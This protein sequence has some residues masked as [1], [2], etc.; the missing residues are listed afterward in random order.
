M[1]RF[2]FASLL[3]LCGLGSR[4][5]GVTLEGV[6]LSFAV[7]NVNTDL[8]FSGAELLDVDSMIGYNAGLSLRWRWS[9]RSRFD[10][11]TEAWYQQAGYSFRDENS[12]VT[13][14]QLPLLLR[15]ALG[16][17]DGS[18]YVIFGPSLG[19]RMDDGESP[20]QADYNDFTFAG[21]AGIGYSYAIGRRFGVHGEFRFHGDFSDAYDGDPDGEFGLQSARHRVFQFSAGVEF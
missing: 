4:A 6:G 3:M 20:V 19:F 15:S 11:V 14:L 9:R 16:D 5:E 10:I 7:A 18:V 8:Q 17:Q 1:R 12:V 2:V 21:E 13:Y